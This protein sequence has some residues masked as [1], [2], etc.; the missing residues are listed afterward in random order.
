MAAE[1]HPEQGNED[2]QKELVDL[3]KGITADGKKLE[4]MGRQAIQA[5]RLSQDVAP[6]MAEVYATIP[7]NSLPRPDWER[8][9]G[10][11]TSW[12]ASISQMSKYMPSITGMT[13]SSVNSAYSTASTSWFGAQG[14]LGKPM[15]PAFANVTKVIERYESADKAIA[16]MK[17]LGLDNRGGMS[18]PATELLAEAKAA[19]ERP[20]VGDG[21]P[22]SIL[23]PL[24][25]SINVAIA[26]LLRRRPQQEPT[27]NAKDKIVSIGRHCGHAS[28]ASGY[29]E[30]IGDEALKLLNE[31]S[32][33]K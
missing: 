20:L 23:L 2:K 10:N 21:G 7:A 26:E 5:G 14:N 31:L 27:G 4:A 24:R 30:K 28:L 1:D 33:G 16:A 15:P 12:R 25:E 17:K 11:W 29:F 22:P 19:M 13:V 8:E 6:E 32:G 18:R 3:L 9:I